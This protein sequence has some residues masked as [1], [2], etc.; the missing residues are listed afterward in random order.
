M[1]VVVFGHLPA[2]EVLAVEELDEAG[3][4]VFFVVFPVSAKNSLHDFQNAIY[5]IYDLSQQLILSN[6]FQYHLDADIFYFY[7][8]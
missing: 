8:V 5:R 6:E 3:V 7:L 1:A 2:A 4:L